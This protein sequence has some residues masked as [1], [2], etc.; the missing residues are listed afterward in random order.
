MADDTSNPSLPGLD[1]EE[2]EA[3][4]ETPRKVR[5][6]ER[7]YDEAGSD[8]LDLTDDEAGDT[9]DDEE[10]AAAG[11]E[12]ELEDDELDEEDDEAEDVDDDELD[13][14]DDELGDDEDDELDEEDGE[15]GDDDEEG[16][17]EEGD[18][19]LAQETGVGG[20][21]DDMDEALA[22]FGAG[23]AGGEPE[24]IDLESLGDDDEDA[25]SI[26]SDTYL[27]ATTA[28]Y[29]ELADEVS[30]ASE[31]EVERQAVAASMAG[32]GSGLLG[33]DDVT[34]R[35]GVTEEEMEHLD[36]A[37]ASDL[38][39]RVAT[40][41]TL[42]AAFVGTLF[43]GGWWFTAFVT[44]IALVGLA[45]FYG[46]L[47]KHGYSPFA[48]AG[49]A[50]VLGGAIGAHARGSAPILGALV[51]TLLLT[52]LFYSLVSRRKPLDNAAV[53][54]FGA[55]W[56]GLL[57]F[58]VVVGRAPDAIPLILF[59]VLLVALFDT[60]GYFVGR[61]F[62]RRPLARQLS[63]RK[64][65]EGYLGGA[66]FTVLVAL[67]L[68]TIDFFPFDL[69]QAGITAG[70]VVLLAPLG[71]LAESMVKRTLGVKDMGSILPGHG[72]MLDRIDSFLFV[73]PVVYLYFRVAGIL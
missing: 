21:V 1:D 55:A 18:E 71:D 51:A 10:A 11:L 32:V 64:T 30:R 25:G 26:S 70:L 68:S 13:D 42:I 24:R 48:I 65:W 16:D 63:P 34:G 22:L 72:G 38:T 3:E 5:P 40:A 7:P 46:T 43:L 14:E 20:S 9:P 31:V 28:E 45:E 33:F 69:A 56:A 61:A 52:S 41:L 57:L 50:G 59:L 27:S 60:A 62:G 44:L 15:H 8:E 47:R 35:K 58:A 2:T 67:I 39:V 36:Q 73:A 53:T 49:L 54:V 29:R 19:M 17:D 66:I 12:D 6:W 4:L 37:A 23:P